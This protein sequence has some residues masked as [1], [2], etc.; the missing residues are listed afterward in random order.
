[1]EEI[2][3]L[4][5]ASTAAYNTGRPHLSISRDLVRLALAKLRAE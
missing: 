4:F 2:T 5:K 3:K 1:M